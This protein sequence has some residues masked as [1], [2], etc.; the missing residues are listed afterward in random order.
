MC[1]TI[2][3]NLE[4]PT[5]TG[6]AIKHFTAF[7]KR[8]KLYEEQVGEKNRDP[9]VNITPTSYR[10]SLDDSFLRMFLTARSIDATQSRKSQKS[11]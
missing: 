7:L 4:A 2:V 1:Q 11:N 8:R 10:A 6:V 3:T 9:G 5:L